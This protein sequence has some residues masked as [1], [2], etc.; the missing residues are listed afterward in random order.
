VRSNRGDDHCLDFYISIYLPVITELNGPM[1]SIVHAL[2]L[3]LDQPSHYWSIVIVAYAAVL[4]S[5]LAAYYGPSR[6]WRWNSPLVFGMLLGLS[7]IAFRWPVCFENV[8]R[9]NPDESQMIAGAIV[10]QS[11]P[12]F[13]Q[14]VDGTTHGPLA[15]WPLAIQGA[16]GMRI[17]FTNARLLS[18]VLAWLTIVFTWLTLRVIFEEGLSRV[19]VL[20]MALF[21]ASTDFWDFTQYSSEHVPVALL[22]GGMWLVVSETF[23]TGRAHRWR[24]SLAGLLLGA[25]P[26]AKLQGTPLGLWI[27]LMAVIFTLTHAGTS[28]R[29]RVRLVA[30]LVG[31]AVAVPVAIAVMV[32]A[33]R[34]WPDFWDSYIESNIRYAKAFPM[35]WTRAWSSFIRLASVAENFPHFFYP[36]FWL[37]IG[38]LAVCCVGRWSQRDLKFLGLTAGL[39]F[40]AI[41]AALAP[42]RP[43]THYLQFVIA[44]T[45][46]ATGAAVGL[47]IRRA[48]TIGREAGGLM[49][50]FFTIVP[51]AIFLA[52]GTRSLVSYSLIRT[53]PS[54]G[55]FTVTHGKLSRPPVADWLINN[56]S[57]DEPVA[58]WGWEPHYFVEANRKHATRE[59]HTALQ[60]YNSPVRTAYVTRYLQ[61]LKAAGP[62]T[63]IDVVGPGSFAFEDRS[64]YAHETAPALNAF[65]TENYRFITEIGSARIYG[66]KDVT[67]RHP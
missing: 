45:A 58:M 18:S 5:A 56:T 37:M 3:W 46:L 66:R 33:N 49:R 29:E 48:N 24:L 16:L 2:L 30:H 22:A 11:S 15:Q 54:L 28:R 31:G 13:W 10:L 67:F 41:Y 21:V 57:V 8:Q 26:F 64:R 62:R 47:V 6:H 39:L 59:A 19:L 38:A 52:V 53:V 1:W 65:L 40:L 55:R 14:H 32:I 50:C 17:D 44:P 63:F 7:I 25:V 60:I 43:F 27:G 12:V 42:N 4:L 35:D 34:I 20:P 51:L 9:D 36:S 23:T 61:D